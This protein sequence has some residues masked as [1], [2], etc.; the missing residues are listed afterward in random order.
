MR[1]EIAVSGMKLATREVSVNELLQPLVDG[2]RKSSLWSVIGWHC[3]LEKLEVGILDLRLGL[4]F[5]DLGPFLEHCF[6]RRECLEGSL[7]SSFLTLLVVPILGIEIP[8]W[9]D[10]REFW[11]GLAE[12]KSASGI[13]H[14]IVEGMDCTDT[15]VSF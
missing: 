11:R 1:L 8:V 5:I 14:V 2:K 6:W 12:G 10:L 9:K 4:C 13:V 3:A 15:V 7:L